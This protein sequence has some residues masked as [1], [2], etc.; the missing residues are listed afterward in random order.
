MLG[1]VRSLYKCRSVGLNPSSVVRVWASTLPPGVCE[2]IMRIVG[3]GNTTTSEASRSQHG[4]DESYHGSLPPDLVV[5]P[6]DVDQVTELRTLALLL[7]LA[8]SIPRSR[9]L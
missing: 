8:L 9:R 1:Y 2:S 3:E 7:T 6:T 5:Y 4:K